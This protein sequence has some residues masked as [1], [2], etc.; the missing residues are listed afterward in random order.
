MQVTALA[1]GADGDPVR[2]TASGL[3]PF[4]LTPIVRPSASISA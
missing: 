1:E 4:G 3:V 2:S